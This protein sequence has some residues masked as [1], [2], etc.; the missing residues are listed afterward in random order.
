M[1]PI[2]PYLLPALLCALFVVTFAPALR[3]L[4]ESWLASEDYTHAFLVVPAVAYMIWQR[5]EYLSGE[6]GNPYAGLALAGCCLL[7]YPLTLVI[8]VN[9][10][11]YLATI[12]F[13]VSM[14]ILFGGF[15]ILLLLALPI[16]LL[17]MT[18]PIPEAA[19]ASLTASLQ[20]WI[21]KVSETVIRMLGIPLVREGNILHVEQ[22]SFQV[23]EACSGVRSLI[24]MSTMSLLIGYYLL[25]RIWSTGLLFLFSLPVAI[26]INLTRVIGLVLAYHYFGLDLSTGL[27]HT[28]S[29]VVLFMFG[30]ALLFAGQ[31]GLELLEQHK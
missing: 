31:K 20:L 27:A 5:R 6:N 21:S 2:K 11:S 25:S 14:L 4:V 24:S 30:L 13:V 17:V 10:L 26:L 16:V 12:G 3:L 18:I 1:S 19:M 23:V 9:T 29:G 8:Q 22:M 15:R 7:L 28:L